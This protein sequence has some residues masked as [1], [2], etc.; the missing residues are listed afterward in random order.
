MEGRLPDST[1][2]ADR[3]SSKLWPSG[4]LA[5]G[6]DSGASVSSCILEADSRL[7][8]SLLVLVLDRL[9][10]LATSGS[11]SEGWVGRSPSLWLSLEDTSGVGMPIVGLGADVSEAPVGSV[12]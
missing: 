3:G 10:V 6:S 7:I 1:K 2:P 11:G 8:P 5:T 12:N 9:R 4:R